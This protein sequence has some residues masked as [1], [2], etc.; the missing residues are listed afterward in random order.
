MRK[1]HEIVIYCKPHVG[2]G[3]IRKA[4]HILKTIST[5][6]EWRYYPGN[7]RLGEATEIALKQST[8]Y[9]AVIAVGGDGTVLEVTNGLMDQYPSEV[10][11][12]QRQ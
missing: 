1:Q 10:I 5:S 9:N 8:G 11:P 3:N 6:W 2:K 12:A 4:S 7:Q